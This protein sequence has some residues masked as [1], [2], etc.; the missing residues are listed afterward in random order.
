MVKT[1]KF[2]PK[3]G[4]VG[5]WKFLIVWICLI[6][7][8]NFNP[9]LQQTMHKTKEP[10]LLYQFWYVFFYFILVLGYVIRRATTAHP[11]Q[12]VTLFLKCHFW[13]VSTLV[14]YVR[15]LRD[16]RTLSEL[17]NFYD[18]YYG[19]IFFFMVSYS[20]QCQL[21]HPSNITLTISFEVILVRAIQFVHAY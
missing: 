8:N 12:Y 14:I 2:Q 18:L 7:I 21:A 15:H 6:F 16:P 13:H 3:V 11:A 19:K 5:N 20:A 10:K 1:T 9:I 17:G 4:T